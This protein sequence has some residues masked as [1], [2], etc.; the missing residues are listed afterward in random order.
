VIIIA[1]GS[2]RNFIIFLIASFGAFATLLSSFDGA[3]RSSRPAY[4][5]FVTAFIAFCMVFI[6]SLLSF[7]LH[8]LMR[9]SI[10][11]ANNSV[12]YFLY[13]Y[14]KSVGKVYR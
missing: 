9:N 7:D 2:N 13:C 10:L 3:T 5:A 12:L 14:R 8:I 1:L 4:E 6:I 11:E